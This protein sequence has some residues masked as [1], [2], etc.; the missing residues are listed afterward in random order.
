ME[1]NVSEH[2]VSQKVVTGMMYKRHQHFK[3]NFGVNMMP[4]VMLVI[5][6]AQTNSM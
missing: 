1:Q 2:E 6:L 5:M 4:F 3:K